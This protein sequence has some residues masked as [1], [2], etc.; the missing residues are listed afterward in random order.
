MSAPGTRREDAG[1]RHASGGRGGRRADRPGEDLAER[2]SERSLGLTAA[3]RTP[4]GHEPVRADNDRAV[5]GDLAMAHPGAAR[6]VQ[7]PPRWPVRSASSGTSASAAS[8][9]A[10]SHQAWPSSPAISRNR[11]PSTGR[12]NGPTRSS[13][14]AAH[15]LDGPDRTGRHA[16]VPAAR[17][18]GFGGHP[19]DLGRRL[20]RPPR[21]KQHPSNPS[22]SPR[23]PAA[24]AAPIL[25][26]AAAFDFCCRH[27]RMTGRRLR[28]VEPAAS[29]CSA[30]GQ[31]PNGYRR[32]RPGARRSRRVGA[33]AATG[34]RGRHLPG[35]VRLRRRTAAD[36]A[37]ADRGPSGQAGA[38][39]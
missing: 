13:R 11:P 8:C 7:G 36:R 29:P 15:H 24:S 1:R 20:T 34:Q 3:G 39:A 33:L 32:T 37:R 38:V 23:F 25:A 18:V 26:A 12:G 31:T 30:A 27:T 5:A 2:G 9:L 21:T 6:V 19:G 22:S 35:A 10:A 16:A 4:P 14:A 28:P 17:A